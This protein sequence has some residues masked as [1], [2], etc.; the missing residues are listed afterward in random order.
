[1]KSI[2]NK[3]L[4]LTFTLLLIMGCATET[5]VHSTQTTSASQNS[6]SMKLY[7]YKSGIVKFKN[8]NHTLT[9]DDWGKKSYETDRNEAIVINNGLEYRINND[10][11]QI[12]KDRNPMLDWL[13][14]AD[15]DLHNYYMDKEAKNAIVNMNKTET[16][17]GVKCNI[18]LDNVPNPSNRY[19]L[20]DNKILLKHQVHNNHKWS[21]V[22]EATFAK[23]NSSIDQSLFSKLPNYPVENMTKYNDSEALHSLLR[24]DP[25]EY[26]RTLI[27]A[28]RIKAK[29]IEK[30]EDIKRYAKNHKEII[31][32]YK[33]H[34]I[35]NAVYYPENFSPDTIKHLSYIETHLNA[36]Q[37]EIEKANG[38]HLDKL[39][40]FYPIRYGATALWKKNLQNSYKQ[41]LNSKK[42]LSSQKQIMALN[43]YFGMVAIMERPIYR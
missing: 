2:Y 42:Q 40:T 9:W 8:K 28:N 38:V 25:D 18:W 26:E 29:A 37:T 34:K 14:V 32:L 12:K 21:V 39:A 16:V 20:Y 27:M 41:F 23:F 30:K 24:K 43:D 22:K 6:S 10:R 1:M 31:E 15:Q 33:N 11:K 36:L 17:A 35:G 13:I 4:I 7:P 19:C 5:P 3:I